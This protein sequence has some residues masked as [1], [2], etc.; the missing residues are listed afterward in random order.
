MPSVSHGLS[1]LL[2]GGTETD[3]LDQICAG[4][5]LVAVSKVS[6]LQVR[7]SKALG[8]MLITTMETT[9]TNQASGKVVAKQ[10]AQAIFY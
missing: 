7:E 3:Y 9:F 8:K 10:R 6:D 1:G 2:D 4:D 5:T